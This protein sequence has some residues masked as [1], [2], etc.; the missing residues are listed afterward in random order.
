[1]TFFRF[2]LALLALSA[3]ASCLSSGTWNEPNPDESRGIETGNP[4]DPLVGKSVL[5]AG[6]NTDEAYRIAFTSKT[7]SEVTAYRVFR[8]SH[9]LA[10]ALSVDGADADP[11]SASETVTTL[12]SQSDGELR[13]DAS[14]SDGTQVSVALTADTFWNFATVTLTIDGEVVTTAFDEQFFSRPSDVLVRNGKT[15]VA[16]YY[17]DW[18]TSPRVFLIGLGDGGSRIF[19]DF[20]G[21]PLAGPVRLT[22]APDGVVVAAS[23]ADERF[24]KGLVV[25]RYLEDGSRNAAFGTK[26]IVHVA[27]ATR[28]SEILGLPDGPLLVATERALVKLKADGSVDA[29]P[30]SHNPF[31]RSRSS[32]FAWNADTF[33]ASIQSVTAGEPFLWVSGV[34]S[35]KETPTDFVAGRYRTDGS[36]D[37]T[38]G[39]DGFTRVTVGKGL[40]LR[41]AFIDRRNDGS[42]IVSGLYQDY[43][44][45]RQG[46]F[47][48]RLTANGVLDGNFS[49][50]GVFRLDTAPLSVLDNDFDRRVEPEGHIYLATHGSSGTLMLHVFPDGTLDPSFTPETTL[51]STLETD[52]FSPRIFDAEVSLTVSEDGSLTLLGDSGDHIELTKIEP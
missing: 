39:T 25:A 32:A 16:G 3:T 35:N 2:F 21:E 18:L 26:G 31:I 52:S 43:F 17:E 15:F 13:L 28:V 50:G 23:V 29:S 46:V 44:H 51:L 10:S 42:L 48:V 38:F 47:A 5:L 20:D 27:G 9:P 19:D 40:Y 11:A 22:S 41:N 6:R 8:G 14:F 7:D 34:V 24:G 33:P 37:T 4:E 12:Y 45:V 49:E 36:R 1:M 30:L